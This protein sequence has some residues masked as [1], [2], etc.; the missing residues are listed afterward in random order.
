MID[1]PAAV[2][3][4][5]AART[6]LEKELLPS[7]TDAR[8]KYQTLVTANVLAIIGREIA[9]GEDALNHDWNWLSERLGLPALQSSRYAALRDAVCEAA[10]SLCR[11]IRDGAYD[12]P[13]QFLALAREIRHSVERKLEIANP[14]YLA[15][16]RAQVKIQDVAHA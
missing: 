2:E 9:G 1:R 13:A 15:N 12:E 3:L 6:Y 10:E 8:L 5:D 4:V 7:L 16:F 11:R 14:R